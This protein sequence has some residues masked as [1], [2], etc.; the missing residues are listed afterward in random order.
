MYKRQHS[1]IR[2]FTTLIPDMLALRDWIMSENCHHIA[3]ESTGIYWSPIYERLDVYKRQVA[4]N[5]WL[6]GGNSECVVV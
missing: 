2:E 6:I 1:E 4:E 3:M 5:E